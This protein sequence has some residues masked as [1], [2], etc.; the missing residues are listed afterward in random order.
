MKTS[1]NFTNKFFKDVIE[2]RIRPIH[3]DNTLTL[4][5]TVLVSSILTSYDINWACLT[6]YQI[7]EAA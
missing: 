2:S 6:A 4:N 7:H 3:V 1:L 5:L